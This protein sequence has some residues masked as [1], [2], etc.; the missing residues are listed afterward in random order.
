MVPP[1]INIHRKAV[2]RKAVVLAAFPGDS[3]LGKGSDLVGTGRKPAKRRKALQLA[4]SVR[5]TVGMETTYVYEGP[6]KS[7]WTLGKAEFILPF[8]NVAWFFSL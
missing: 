1:L 3:S 8:K 5:D 4:S 2:T 6:S 7:R